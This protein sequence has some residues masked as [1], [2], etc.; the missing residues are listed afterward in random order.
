MDSFASGF[1]Q[2]DNTYDAH[3]FV[4]YLDLVHSLPFF[5]ECKTQSYKNLHLNPG[6]SVLEIGCG[7]GVD[8]HKISGN[9]GKKGTA[10]GIDISSTMLKTARNTIHTV[11]HCPEFVLCN[12]QNLAFHDETFHAVRSDR[13]LQHTSDPFAV[14]KEI[15]RVTRPSGSVVIFEPDW[16]TFAI[17]P[18]DSKTLRKVLN[19][20]CD[21]IPSGQV[22]R[23]LFAAFSASGLKEV[24]VKPYTLVINDLTL[25]KQIFDLDTTFSHV[26]QQGIAGMSEVEHLIDD[27]TSADLSGQFFSSLT[28]F[29]VSGKKPEL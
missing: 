6:D 1:A 13:V 20:W 18:G 14:V 27:L 15:A 11:N 5:Q 23:S 4:Q 8:I 9:V 16:E 17:W 21:K 24:D 10:V 2:V 25:A 26:I 3:S 7:N 28:F 22:G 29:M 12:G 19:F